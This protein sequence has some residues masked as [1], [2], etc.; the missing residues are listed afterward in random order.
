LLSAEIRAIKYLPIGFPILTVSKE[1][2]SESIL[3]GILFQ[4]Y[5]QV[6]LGEPILL[7]VFLLV[8]FFTSN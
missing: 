4:S 2:P 3:A 7:L 6:N 5:F 1:V 8:A